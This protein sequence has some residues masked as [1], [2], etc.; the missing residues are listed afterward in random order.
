M[1]R[2]RKIALIVTAA[3]WGLSLLA[4]IAGVIIVQ[5]DWFRTLV[6]TKIVAAVE[7]ATGGTAEIG[8][9]TFDWHHLRADVRDFVLH[10]LEGRDAAPLFRAKL[11]EVDLKLLSPFKGFVDIRRLFVDTPQANVIVYPDGHTNIPAPKL[12]KPSDKSGLET[13]VD[14]AIGQFELRNGSLTFGTRKTAITSRA[15]T[16]ARSSA[17]TRSIR[18]TRAKSRS[19]R[20]T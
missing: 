7:D 14:L 20:W 4:L 10:G 8:A 13:I 18:N 9:F 11:L 17:T 1:S 2:C 16:F 15:R 6:R 3:F 19:V 5:T 12:Q